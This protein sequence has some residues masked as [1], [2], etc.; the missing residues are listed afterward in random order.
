MY[1][2]YFFLSFFLR[3]YPQKKEQNRAMS[4][5][6]VVFVNLERSVFFLV[7]YFRFTSKVVLYEKILGELRIEK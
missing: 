4:P 1:G 3:T 6:C 5:F 7:S 2:Q